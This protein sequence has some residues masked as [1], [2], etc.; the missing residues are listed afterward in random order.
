MADKKYWM[1]YQQL[2]NEKNPDYL[3]TSAREFSSDPFLEA[4]DETTASNRRDFLKFFGFSVGATAALAACS[5]PVRYALPYV[6]K[7]VEA[8]PGVAD[9]YASTF[10][11]G[12][13][14]AS[15]LVKTREGRPIK[16]EGNPD[17]PITRGGVGARGHA[18]VLS[19]YD[20]QRYQAP[21][22]TKGDSDPEK[23]DAAIVES[24]KS[25]KEVAILTSTLP[26]PSTKALIAEFL[27]KYPGRHV[28]Y[29]AVSCSAILEAH[30]ATF[31]GAPFLP[32]FRFDKADLI[33]GINA[34]F[35]GTWISPVEFTKQYVQGRKFDE[36]TKKLSRHLQ[37]ETNLTVTGANADL[38]IPMKPSQEGAVVLKIYNELA[39][40]LGKEK[41]A[42]ANIELAG[43]SVALAA[44]ELLNA[45]G[46]AILVCG[47]N[48]PNVQVLVN[49]VNLMIEAYGNTI[50]VEQKSNL[51]QGLDKD[52]KTLVA[53]MAAGKIGTLIVVDANPAYSY[54]D[55][56]AFVDAMK[57]VDVKVSLTEAPDETSTLCDYVVPNHTALESWGDFEPYAG[58]YSLRQP[59]ISPIFKTRQF[60][61]SLLK[62]M[63]DT[64]DYYTYLREY[65]KA[66][67]FEKG[68]D[69]ETAWKKAVHDGVYD[70]KLA[71][72]V[73]EEKRWCDVFDNDTVSG[74]FPKPKDENLSAIATA[75]AAAYGDTKGKIDLLLYQKVSIGDGKLAQN[76]WLQE[77]P[78]P[79]TRACWDNYVTISKKLA[80]ANGLKNEDLVTVKAGN[81]TV[82]LPVLI[83]PG[84]HAE[85]IGIALG[86]GRTVAGKAAV[87][88][89]QNAYPAARFDG[90]N[91]HYFVSGVSLSPT[92]ERYDLAFVQINGTLMGRNL[93]KETTLANYDKDIKEHKDERT[94]LRQ[95]L[96]TLFPDREYTGHHW[97]MV[98][99]LNECTG[100]GACVVS[101]QV[102]NNVPVVGKTEVRRGR[103]MHWIRIDRYY[104]TDSTPDDPKDWNEDPGENP[105][106]VFEPM[107]CQ[108]CNN[109]PC[110]NVCPV[111]ATVHS[112]EGLNQQAYNRCFG[113]RYCANNCPYKVR[114]F[115]WLDYTFREDQDGLIHQAFKTEFKYNPAIDDLGR[116]VLN[117]DVTVRAR[118]V[119]EKCSFCV[120]RLQ[121]GKL[122]AKT[123][124]RPLR[125]GEIQTACS[126]SCPA[127][128]IKFGDINDP[129]S[130][131]A[132]YF[133]NE[134]AFMVLEEIKTLPNI[135]Y[136]MKVRNEP[137]LAQK[138]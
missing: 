121:A 100:C 75:V 110:E 28:Q 48:D 112:S 118:G 126:Q 134:R 67:V 104:S 81:F 107:L 42:E 19:V 60:Q 20:S 57:S 116:M 73:S 54:P 32:R 79:I 27:K 17:S 10:F 47:S 15:V 86:Y 97:A 45:K 18:H 72:A 43:N 66:N 114:R 38:R 98:I 128:A 105:K 95:H 103:D 136:L 62:W 125:D 133:N 65:W 5:T 39:A 6:R 8:L 119:M 44:R 22:T 12:S 14:Y 115:N 46:R 80:D 94:K 78:D 130:V 4:L 3:K 64:R 102:E 74:K 111:L 109:A 71:A 30:A 93:V 2:E 127:G 83:Q 117:P 37:F 26:S 1:S 120:Q 23:I 9:Y 84:Q 129:N 89:G 122:K 99:D 21:G 52:V 82:T 92:G 25:G 70:K 108:H 69:F 113:T 77:M 76:P 132:K 90:D 61:D 49:A 58:S 59:S 56:K 91:V 35:L 31:G 13:E 41:L 29:D 55:A 7:P 88:V 124:G 33:V 137:Q 101:C 24:L 16:I 96:V 138:A 51:R 123:E 87:G 50:D 34:D 131:V 106:V 135:S 85:T 11:D 36:T 63:G 53:D 40:A 68:V